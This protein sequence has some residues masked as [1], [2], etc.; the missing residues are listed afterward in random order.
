VKDA[1]LAEQIIRLAKIAR[2]VA[3]TEIEVVVPQ[4]DDSSDSEADKIA[5]GRQ[6]VIGPRPIG[7]ED[8]IF[9]ALL[10]RF[11]RWEE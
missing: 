10:M 7:N 3:H 2:F 6:V 5:G 8:L 9:Q 4:T 1:K 11:L